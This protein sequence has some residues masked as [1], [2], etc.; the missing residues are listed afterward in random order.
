MT[1]GQALGLTQ[2]FP[3][4]ASVDGH[5]QSTAA[6]ATHQAPGRA[7]MLPHGCEYFVRIGGIHDHI[8]DT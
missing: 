5:V 2:L 8:A 4:A 7:V 1:I 6:A 3:V